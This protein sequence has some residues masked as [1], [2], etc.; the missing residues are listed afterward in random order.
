MTE[1]PETPANS[2]LGHMEGI[3]EGWAQHEFDDGTLPEW[4]EQRSKLA[5]AIANWISG[6]VGNASDIIR[7]IA[8][9]NGLLP[10]PVNLALIQAGLQPYDQE[11][12]AR[13]INLANEQIAEAI[14]EQGT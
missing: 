3:V 9:Q 5:T 8:M 7:A 14:R 2:L 13:L 6:Y 1:V 12:V 10:A 4:G 11:E